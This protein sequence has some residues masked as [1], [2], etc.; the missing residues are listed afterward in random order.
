MNREST[1]SSTGYGYDEG[2][3]K[4]MLN[5]FNPTAVGLAVSGI[6]AYLTYASGLIYPLMAGPLAWIVH[7]STIRNDF[8]VCPSGNNWS[9]SKIK[10]FYYVLLQ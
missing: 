10:N 9:V 1:L 2:L 4:F 5:M 3:R 8:L 6:V 7:V